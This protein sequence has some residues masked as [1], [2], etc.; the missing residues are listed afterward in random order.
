MAYN[1]EDKFTQPADGTVF[2]GPLTA[3][4]L[5]EGD[6]RIEQ[7]EDARAVWRDVASRDPERWGGRAHLVG[8]TFAE[9]HR[10]ELLRQE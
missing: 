4:E 2:L 6:A 5:R 1:P 7:G 9:I 3:D 8:L 10:L